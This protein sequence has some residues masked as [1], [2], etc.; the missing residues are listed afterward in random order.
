MRRGE[1]TDG[2]REEVRPADRGS[3]QDG[4]LVRRQL[5]DPGCEEG[6]DRRRN[7]HVGEILGRDPSTIGSVEQTVLDQLREHL[8]DEQRRPAGRIRDPLPNL[9]IEVRRAQ[10]VPDQNVALFRRQ[11][12]ERDRE[13]VQ[14]A[15]SPSRPHLQ[16][17]GTGHRQEEERSAAREVGDVLHQIQER[18]P[19]PLDVVEDHDDGPLPRERLEEPANGPRDL[20]RSRGIGHTGQLGDPVGDRVPVFVVLQ[21]RRHV[22]SER[23]RRCRGEPTC[24]LLHDLQDGEEGRSLTV[25]EA[26]APIDGG[27]GHVDEEL[28]DQPRLAH[29]GRPEDGHQAT[30]RIGDGS[31]ERVPEQGEC[32]LATDHR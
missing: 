10:E 15:A 32:A 20:L 21:Q 14:L 18:R 28:L 11:G 5:I 1:G 16:Q 19:S 29:S 24:R 12:L 2:P 30:R 27:L 9:G 31:F 17:I 3:F 22:V 4:T 23:L 8:L 13:G 6:C 25:R 7:R 26:P